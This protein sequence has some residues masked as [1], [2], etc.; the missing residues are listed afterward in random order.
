VDKITIERF[1]QIPLTK[2]LTEGQVESLLLRTQ[3]RIVSAGETVFRQGESATFLYFVEKGTIIEVGEDSTGRK[4]VP[5]YAGQRDYLGRYAMVTGRPFRVTAKAVE[6]TTLL[7]I[8]LRDLQPIL[9][10][11]DDW[12]GWFFRTDVAARL[13]A[14]PLFMDFD[15]W[16]IYLLAD[17]V[18]VKEYKPDQTIFQAGDQAESLCVIDQGQVIETAPSGTRSPGDWPRY[19]AAG[20]HFGRYSLLRGER[21]RATATARKPTRIYHIPRQIL[22][23]LLQDRPSDLPD[24]LARP[25]LVARLRDVPLFSGLSDEHLRLLAGYVSLVFH[26]P[27][28][29][30]S[31]QGEPATSLMILDDGEAVVRLQVGQAQPR[32]VTYLKARREEATVSESVYFGAHCLQAEELRGATVEVT[33]PSTWIVLEKDDFQTFLADAGLTPAALGEGSQ[34]DVQISTPPSSPTDRLALPYQTRRHWIVLVTRLLLPSLLMIGAA[35]LLAADLVFPDLPEDL[36]TLIALASGVAVGLL[37]LWTAWRYVDWMND[38]FVVSNQAVVHLERVLLISEERYEVPLEQIQNVNINVGIIGRWLGYGDLSVDT[39]AVE[40]HVTFTRI[41]DPEYVQEL[42]QQASAQAKSGQRIQFRESIRQQLEEH[43]YPERLK[44]SAPESVILQA[45]STQASPPRRGPRLRFL[46]DLLPRFEVREPDRITWRKHW[47]NLVQRTGLPILAFL[48]TSYLALA[49]M[50]AFAT[51]ALGMIP[52]V[53]LPPVS[54]LGVQGWVCLPVGVLW[55]MNLL[56]LIY[57]YVDWRNDVYI[58]TD[59]EVIDEERQ[60]IFFPFWFLYTFDR[61]QAPLANVQNVNL[62]IPNLLAIVFNYGD[63]IVQTAGAEGTL[64]FLFVSNPRHVQAEVLR[65]LEAYRRR[66]RERELQE[67]WSGMPEW[68]D[69]YRVVTE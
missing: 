25:D 7:A 37:T 26:R 28:D 19:F 54:L 2:K 17:Q 13:R 69:A 49:H 39:A 62:D 29:I 27:G 35:F 3:E 8:P 68:F 58:V 9:F 59:N 33:Q 66:E 6:D 22:R 12:R 34:L 31:R 5:R 61:K 24:E 15:D 23:A 57:Q 18:E 30:V 51:E 64:D 48:L 11:Y 41:P 32:P 47:F 44:P 1:Q 52:P 16:D 21:R 20:N 42:I 46:G 55:V 63:V 50:L 4:T 56:W 67:R 43:L 40:G 38:L 45:S 14:M 10:S 53:Q 65:R 36:Q 60:P